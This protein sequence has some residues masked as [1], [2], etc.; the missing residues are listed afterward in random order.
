MCVCVC[1]RACMHVCVCVCVRACV[2]ACMCVYVCLCLLHNPHTLNETS[3]HS[4]DH[5]PPQVARSVLSSQE[6]QTFNYY[7]SQ[8]EHSGLPVE[9]LVTPLLD[10]LNTAEKVRT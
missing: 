5:L 1:V 2:H 9:D 10:L 7:V 3:D 8:Y 4:L 6:H